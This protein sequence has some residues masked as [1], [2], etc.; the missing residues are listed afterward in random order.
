MQVIAGPFLSNIAPT[1]LL[2]LEMASSCSPALADRRVPNAAHR[3]TQQKSAFF[4][5]PASI[6]LGFVIKARVAMSFDPT[7]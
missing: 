4:S 3:T 5:F 2:A 1:L 7:Q 6:Y